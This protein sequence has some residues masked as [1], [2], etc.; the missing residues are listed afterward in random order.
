M[1]K[2]CWGNCWAVK[3]IDSE[4][5]DVGKNPLLCPWTEEAKRILFWLLDWI[6]KWVDLNCKESIA[7]ASIRSEKEITSEVLIQKGIKDCNRCLVL[8]ILVKEYIK[9]CQNDLVDVLSQ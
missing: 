6:F 1:S 4:F 3:K 8:S 2:G 7:N 9:S 5:N